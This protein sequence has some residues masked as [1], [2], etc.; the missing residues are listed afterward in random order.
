MFIRRNEFAKILA[1]HP[2]YS[3]RVGIAIPLLEP[4]DQG[5]PTNTEIESLNII[6]DKLVGSLE[7]KSRFHYRFCL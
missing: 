1:T 5:L 2:E 7:L 3:Y 4:N 6:E